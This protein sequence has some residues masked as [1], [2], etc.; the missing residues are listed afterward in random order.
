[1]LESEA[2]TERVS[3]DDGVVSGAQIK[4]SCNTT[5]I[6]QRFKLDR[7]AT[8]SHLVFPVTQCT[9]QDIHALPWRACVKSSQM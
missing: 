2:E 4:E 5:I 6:P 3:Q 1:M 9:A 8:W 7:N